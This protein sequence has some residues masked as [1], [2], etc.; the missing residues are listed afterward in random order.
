MGEFDLIARYFK[1]PVRRAALGGG[2]DCAL[3]QVSP[4][5]QI[6]IS[7]DMLVQG[8][9]FFAD[10]DP[11]KLGHKAL[12]VNLSDLAACGSRPLAFLLAL[13]LPTADDTWLAP[14]S[15]GLLALAD[16]HE[17]ELIG[18]DT[19]IQLH[20]DLEFGQP[21]AEVAQGFAEFLLAGDAAR[22]I[23]LAADFGGGIEQAD[24][25]AALGELGRGG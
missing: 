5:C 3:L 24:L 20:I 6:A 17:C 11:F 15:R 16:A 18:G 2:D 23:E 8:R 7:C 21:G 9:H 19:T 22:E 12:A 25:V 10:A 13:A 14:F 1:R 4:G